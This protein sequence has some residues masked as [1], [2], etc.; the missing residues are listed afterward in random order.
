MIR[1]QGPLFCFKATVLLALGAA[2][3][4]GIAGGQTA[5]TDKQK[6]ELPATVAKAFAEKFPGGEIEKLDV[7]VEGGV[8]VYDIEFKNGALE[9]ETDIAADGTVLEVT[10][11]VEAKAVPAAAMKAI[12]KAAEG[13]KIGRIEKVA[14]SFETKNSKVVKLLRP[15]THYAV[16]ITR[17]D[18]TSEVVV[19]A[20][21]KPV[22]D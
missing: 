1:N 4:M 13:G 9:Q 18:R 12:T 20:E 8:A 2:G 22:K 19:T 7:D 3:A 21:G 16:E 14:I 17:G 10:L 11:V 15:V 6:A 5:M